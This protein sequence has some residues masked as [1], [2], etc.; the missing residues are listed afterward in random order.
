MGCSQ[1]GPAANCPS[2]VGPDYDFGASPILMKTKTGR[3]VLAAGQ[4]SGLVY[5]LDPDDGRL[6][7]TTRV[8]TGSALGGIEWGI[9]ADRRSLYVPVADAITLME[10]ARKGAPGA[11]PARPGLYALDPADGRLLWSA[12]AP[13]APCRY[14]PSPR[15]GTMPCIRAQSAAP[16]VIPGAVFSGAMDGW[17]RAYDSKTGRILWAFSTTAQTYETVNGVKAQ[18]GGAID[19]QGPTIAGGRVFVMSGFNGASRVGGNGVNVLL[20]FSVDGR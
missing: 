17:F 5:G 8:G 15:G 1:G 3:D 13:V 2:P 14:A 20:A 10:E 6:L 19:G 11:P 18:P 4:K 9:G 7:W 12:P 16:A